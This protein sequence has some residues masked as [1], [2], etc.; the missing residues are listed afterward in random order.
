MKDE[1]IEKLIEEINLRESKN[2]QKM[3]I[4]QLSGELRDAMS[5]EIE[6]F[7]KIDDLEKSGTSSDL[8]NYAR[9]I[10]K[11]STGRQIAEIQE[12]YL[13]KIDNKYLNTK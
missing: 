13:K 5:Y 2:Y 12:I 6:I 7:Q 4:E 8:A 9:I 10:A 1:K 11:N 3:E